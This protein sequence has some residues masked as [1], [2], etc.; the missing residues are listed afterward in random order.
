VR[1]FFYLYRPV[2]TMCTKITGAQVTCIHVFTF[3]FSTS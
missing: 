2:A 3:Y 1:I